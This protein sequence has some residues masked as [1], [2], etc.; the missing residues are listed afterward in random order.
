MKA[1]IREIPGT[2]ISAPTLSFGASAIG[3]IFKPVERSQA[4]ETVHTALE[5][6]MTYLD[7]SPFYGNSQEMLGDALRGVPRSAYYLSTKVGRYGWEEFDYSYDRVTASVHESLRI[8]GVDHLDLVFL[9]DVEYQDGR[10]VEQAL[11]EGREALQDL[12]S[13]GVIGAL[14]LATASIPLCERAVSQD[15]VDA[16]L[17]HNHNC[18][19]DDRLSQLESLCELH[20]V[21]LIGA[22]PLASGLL[23]SHEPP[24]W[25]PVD[26]YG[27]ELLRRAAELCRNAGTT[28]ESLAVRFSARKTPALTTLVSTSRASH[29]LEQVG[30]L[31]EDD[32]PAT[33]SAVL[34][35]LEPLRNRDWDYETGSES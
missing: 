18:L 22:S 11:F 4:I 16:V 21:G 19:L 1:E 7:T 17:V 24:A 5:V 33:E 2:A 15:L 9:H 20:D 34:Q 35:I 28:I 29:V 6:G 25:H 26:A 13:E 14:G 30:F 32:D 31:S 23:T 27:R 8:L 10:N 12:R 3:G